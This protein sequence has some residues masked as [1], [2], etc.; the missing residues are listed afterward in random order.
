MSN[1]HENNSWNKQGFFRIVLLFGFFLFF[2][3]MVSTGNS[4]RY[5]SPLL[6]PFLYFATI[7]FFLLS[8]VQF[9][10]SRIEI[11]QHTCECGHH[12]H[13]HQQSTFRK[14]ISFG[15]LILPL[16]LVL[17]VP[18]QVPGSALAATKGVQVG[19]SAQSANNPGNGNNAY[20]NMAN[21][22]KKQDKIIV[23]DSNY[24][25]VLNIL[26]LY[27][28]EFVGKKMQ[29]NG[30]VYPA[31]SYSKKTVGRALII[32]CTADA[33]FYG[34]PIIGNNLENFK[35]DTWVSIEGTIENISI[36]SKTIACLKAEKAKKIIA[37]SNPYIYPST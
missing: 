37:P 3:W 35:Q 19:Y 27:P 5:L 12:H 16:L 4:R 11:H 20:Q 31:S 34:I 22:L 10:K 23:N 26:E 17:I 8:I 14:V 13:E 36:N 25:M 32:C 9:K 21:E 1:M 18:Y 30:M 15:L 29:I 33:I 24:V 2:L 7:V 28:N 6:S